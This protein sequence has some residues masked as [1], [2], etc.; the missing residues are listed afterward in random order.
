MS[1]AEIEARRALYGRPSAE[2]IAELIEATDALAASLQ[3]LRT[4]PTPDGGERIAG[5]ASAIARSA[6][7]L[8]C[9]LANEVAG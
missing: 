5:Q 9:V 7:Q 3:T 8:V 4:T 2:R 6:A 1:P